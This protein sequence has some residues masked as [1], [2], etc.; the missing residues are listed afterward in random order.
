MSQTFPL[1]VQRPYALRHSSCCSKGSSSRGVHLREMNGMNEI[2]KVGDRLLLSLRIH[3]TLFSHVLLQ[4]LRCG[5]ET[6]VY[7]TLDVG[8]LIEICLGSVACEH[9]AQQAS[10]L[11]R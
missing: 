7:S 9:D 10:I 3:S 8:T 1:F 2:V 4:V 5:D 6:H 11:C